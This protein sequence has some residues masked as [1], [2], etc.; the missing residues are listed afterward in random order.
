MA[1]LTVAANYS[2]NQS[3]FDFSNLFYGESYTRTSTLFRVTYSD[4]VVEEFRG[5]GFMYDAYGEPYAGTVTSFG[6]Y[7]D[8]QRLFIVEGASVAVSSIVDAAY[9]WDT[10]DDAGVIIN[11]LKGNDTL[12]GGNLAD[13]VMGFDGNDF[14]NGNGGNDVLYGYDGS[15]TIV[16]GA[17]GDRIDGGTGLDTASYAGAAAAVTASLANTSFNTNDASGDTYISIE[18][19]HGSVNS[20]VLYGNAGANAINGSSGNDTLIGGGGPDKLI[21]ATGVDAASYAGAATGVIADLGNSAANTGDAAGDTYSSVE[22]IGGSS[23]GDMLFGNS[24]GNGLSGGIGNDALAGRAG[25]DTLYGGA[26]ADR[27]TGGTGADRFVF[28][29]LSES[30][31]SLVDTILDFTTTELDRIDLS[32]IDANMAS[33]GNQVFT[34]I[35]SANFSGAAGQLRYVK[36]ASDTYIYGDVNGDKVADLKI[37]LDDAV[38]LTKDYF[39]L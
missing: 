14:V 30:A 27:L 39:V 18:N 29:S 36:E 6:G 19:L 8:G 28:K 5:A 31:G 16:G 15:D 23:Y 7:D 25:D 24:G 17:G 22:N 9:T 35:S 33:G 38:I 10:S 3:Y 4:G 26:G 20:D 13:V 2:F 37:H 32:A 21:G 11:A 34:F 12:I 1:T